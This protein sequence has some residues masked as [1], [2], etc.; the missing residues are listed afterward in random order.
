M[1]KLGVKIN[2]DSNLTSKDL[3]LEHEIT[4]SDMVNQI[5]DTIKGRSNQ[6]ELNQYIESAYVHVLPKEIDVVLNKAGLKFKGGR[7][8][9][10]YNADVVNFFAEQYEQGVIESL[11]EN[12]FT[13]FNNQNLEEAHLFSKSV[14]NPNKGITILDFDD[15]LATTKSLVRYTKP[16]GTTGTLTPEQYASTYESLLGLGYKF[17]FSEF[18]KVVDGKPA[19]L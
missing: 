8:R 1:Y 7:T 15:T 6:A 18:N 13:A 11:P 3:V 12:L 17:D 16:D 5:Q 4:V 19:P 14:N 2:K 9:Y 10:T